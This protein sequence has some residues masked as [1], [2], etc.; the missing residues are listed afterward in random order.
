[1]NAQ[2]LVDECNTQKFN[3]KQF[4]DEMNIA[5]L[6]NDVIKQSDEIIRNKIIE[7]K[8]K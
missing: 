1:M 7:D 8:I 3:P 4:R 2:T 6:I 5:W